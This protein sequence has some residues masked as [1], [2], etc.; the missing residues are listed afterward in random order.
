MGGGVGGGRESEPLALS[1]LLELGKGTLVKQKPG[2]EK[3]ED[4]EEN[5]S[6]Q[7]AKLD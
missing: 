3:R 4:K 6:T 7:R 5:D 2:G 1:F